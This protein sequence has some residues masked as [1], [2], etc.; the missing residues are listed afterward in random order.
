MASSFRAAKILAAVADALQWPLSQRGIAN[1]LHY[2][3]N[4]IFV[5]TSE[6]KVVSQRSN[7]TDRFQSCGVPLESYGTA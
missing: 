5:E 6:D 2:L 3:D 4:F 7:L 1:L